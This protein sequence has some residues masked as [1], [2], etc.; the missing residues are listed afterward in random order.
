MLLEVTVYL[1]T[2]IVRQAVHFRVATKTRPKTLRQL[3]SKFVR[4]R[5]CRPKTTRVLLLYDK[6]TTS[7][8]ENH[9]TDVHGMNAINC[10]V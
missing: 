10:M 6:V 3:A 1:S 2:E 8:Y 7:D 9:F 4:Q 5:R